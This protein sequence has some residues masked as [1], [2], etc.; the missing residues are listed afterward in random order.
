M[1]IHFS[2]GIPFIEFS[3]TVEV[4]EDLLC[5]SSDD[6]AAFYAIVRG[7]DEGGTDDSEDADADDGDADE[8]FSEHESW[9]SEGA[10]GPG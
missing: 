2:P 5:R 6:E 10:E 1:R 4:R 8:D 3:G 7:F 9:E